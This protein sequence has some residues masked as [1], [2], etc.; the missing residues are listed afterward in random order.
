M[1]RIGKEQYKYGNK[2]ILSLTDRLTGVSDEDIT[3]NYLMSSLVEFFNRNLDF[4]GGE[5]TVNYKV[6]DYGSSSLSLVEL[7]NNANAINLAGND[8]QLFR[9]VHPQTGLEIKLFIGTPGLR[10]GSGGIPV[11]EADLT[12]IYTSS[13]SESIDHNET[14]NYDYKRHIL[15]DEDSIIIRNNR[16]VAVRVNDHDIYSDVPA[17]ANFDNDVNMQSNDPELNDAEVSA[18]TVATNILYELLDAHLNQVSGN[19]H[20]VIAAEI[21]DFETSVDRSPDV[22]ANTAYRTI[23]HL[24]LDQKGDDNGVA[25][26]I[27][28]LIPIQYVPGYAQSDWDEIVTSSPAFIA[29]KPADITN[30]SL[31]DTDELDE[32]L[33]NLYFTNARV[34]ANSTVLSNS[35]Y[36]LVD[37]IPYAEKGVAGGVVPLDDNIKIDPIHLPSYVDDVEEFA[38]YANFPA[39]G[40]TNVIYVALDSGLSYRWGGTTYI[41]ISPSSTN[42]V[43]GRT[44]SIIA[45]TGDYTSA[46]II[47]SDTNFFFTVPR[48]RLSLGAI[49]DLSYDSN[50]GIFAYNAPVNISEFYNDEQYLKA[51][52]SMDLSTNQAV[53]GHKSFNDEVTFTSDIHITTGAILG[54]VF[55]T[56]AAGNATWEAP[57]GGHDAVSIIGQTYL[58]LTNQ[59]I[60]A[61]QI[62]LNAHVTGILP[63]AN[64][65][66]G[67]GTFD[68]SKVAEID[69]NNNFTVIQDFLEGIDVAG[70]I[71]ALDGTSTNWNIAY[72][73]S[74]INAGNPHNIDASDVSAEPEFTKNSAFNKDFGIIAGTVAHGDHTHSGDFEPAF[75]KNSGFNKLLGSA[76]GQ[77]AEGNDSRI[78]N[79]QTAY[80]WGDHALQ[81]Y[82]KSVG[83][84]LPTGGGHMTGP[85]IMD[86]NTRIIFEDSTGGQGAAMVMSGENWK[87]IEPEAGDDVWLEYVDGD[88]LY[89]SGIK[90]ST[91]DHSHN[92]EPQFTKNG[93]FNKNFGTTVGTVAEGNHAHAYEPEFSKN[94]G[95]NKD[96]GISA[97]TVAEGDHSHEG[98]GVST[99][100][101][102]SKEFEVRNASG[103]KQWTLQVGTGDSLEIRNASDIL[104]FVLEQDGNVLVKGDVSAYAI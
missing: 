82:I 52:N 4:S 42:S 29:N 97:G 45:Q 36:R 38:S 3:F 48:V 25:P 31:H 55:T 24:P 1:G 60:N 8:Y 92:Y 89:I 6:V 7:T 50:T 96:F 71:T 88:G 70:V 98:G 68:L 94:T 30:L 99:E 23:G 51:G 53:L 74:Q 78:L 28:G 43:F 80:D 17:N 40:I 18:T 67:S 104:A 20:A 9:R 61:E 27:G 65:G 93:A 14:I 75:T 100:S 59:V 16:L 90:A 62:N 76:G 46:M 34:A 81:G 22:A 72:L 86:Y 15:A 54:Y 91:V 35:A 2:L 19:P 84:F 101:V 69:V 103:V 64:G 10:G 37:H 49:G 77:V 26:L 57:T 85:I 41:V 66:T 83:S 79:G 102:S 63:I 58:D 21:A 56:D 47:E 12:L 32:G 95:F 33:T 73:H 87:L 44:G 39:L 5:D 13:V 11:T